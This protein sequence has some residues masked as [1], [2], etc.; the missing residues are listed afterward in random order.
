MF[1]ELNISVK[2]VIPFLRVI[3]VVSIAFPSCRSDPWS[4]IETLPFSVVSENPPPFTNERDP[5]A[6]AKGPGPDHEI[7]TVIV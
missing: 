1:F 6:N 7:F 3:S 2:T 5:D 4:I